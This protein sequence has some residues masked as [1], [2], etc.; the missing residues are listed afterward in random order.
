MTKFLFLDIDGVLNTH[1]QYNLAKAIPGWNSN[2]PSRDH[3]MA[4]LCRNRI[5]MINEICAATG[6]TI[7][8]SSSWRHPAAIGGFEAADLLRD[9]GLIPEIVDTTGPDDF[10]GHDFRGAEILRY[11]Q[12]HQIGA[13]DYVIIDDDQ[14]AG[15]LVHRL[16][17][18]GRWIRTSNKDG[19]TAKHRDKAIAALNQN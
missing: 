6:A 2:Q 15:T 17:H 10:T 7:I 19:L 4:L 8:L 14:G 13:K 16:G 1:R 3:L 11:I 12:T 18:R 5:A 9:A